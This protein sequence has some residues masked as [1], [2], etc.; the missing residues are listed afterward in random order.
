[1]RTAVLLCVALLTACASTG[2]DGGFGEVSSTVNSRTGA[3]TKWIRSEQDA[4]AVRDRVKELLAKPL[5]P[6]EAVQLALINN[7]GL[8]ASY[9]ELGIAAGDLLS[10]VLPNPH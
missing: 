5:Q 10:V 9:A 2:P 1:M 4:K 7:P 6:D 8:Q 3:E